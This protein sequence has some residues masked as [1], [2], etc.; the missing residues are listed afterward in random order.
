MAKVVM[1]G[2]QSLEKEPEGPLF[3]EDTFTAENCPNFLTEFIALLEE[4]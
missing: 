2:A 3:F 4:N 1:F